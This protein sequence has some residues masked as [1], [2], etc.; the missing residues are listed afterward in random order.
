VKAREWLVRATQD[1]PAGVTTR[2]EADTLQG[3]QA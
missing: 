3:G 2:V 1:L